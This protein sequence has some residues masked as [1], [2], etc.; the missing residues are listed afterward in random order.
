MRYFLIAG[1]KSGDLHAGHLAEEI[2]KKDPSAITQG[3]GGS[4]MA[5]AGVELLQSYDELAFMGL[6]FVFHFR[7]VIRLFRKCKREIEDFAPDVLILI[8]YS[9]FNLRIAKWAKKEGYKVVYYIA[10]KTWAW[11]ASRNKS[12]KKYIDKLLVILPFE[13]TYFKEKGIE[14]SYVGNPLKEYVSAFEPL[15]NFK[16][17][18]PSESGRVVALL[19]GSRKKEIIRSTEELRKLARHFPEIVFVVATISDVDQHL[20]DGFQSIPNCIILTDQTYDLLSVADAAIVTSGTA[21]LETALFNIP[22]VVVYK[23]NALTYFIGSRLVKLKYI[24][25]VNL[26]VDKEAIPELIQDEFN[27]AALKKHLKSLLFD[28]K[29][30][31]NQL[32]Y[33]KELKQALGSF[34]SS[35]MAADSIIN[36]FK[37]EK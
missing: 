25:L 37:L 33:Y 35:E 18:L 21:T 3:W 16:E 27:T 12:I 11:N 30:R 26:I 22:Q 29:K 1:E 4:V 23:T 13:E 2:Y 8:D 20:Y 15:F 36:T 10:P 17:S 5:K 24:S 7:T 9:G 19:P 32:A 6:D 31:E 34:K 14:T 28:T